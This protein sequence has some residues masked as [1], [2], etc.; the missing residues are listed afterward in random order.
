MLTQRDEDKPIIFPLVCIS[1]VK[2][3]ALLVIS[4]NKL[5]VAVAKWVATA[6]VYIYWEDACLNESIS[7]CN[8]KDYT[9]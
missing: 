1:A 9:A 2:N 4:K 7:E 3:I 5:I 8:L 6:L